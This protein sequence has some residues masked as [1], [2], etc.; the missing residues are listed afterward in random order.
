[1]G[2]GR[3]AAARSGPPAFAERR[4]CL[5]RWAGAVTR[6]QGAG[7]NPN[8][9]K[10][11]VGHLQVRSRLRLCSPKMATA[12]EHHEYYL[13]RSYL[14]ALDGLR[15]ISIVMVIWHHCWLTPPPG[16]WGK[17]PVGVQLFFVI[18]G[19]LVTTLLLRERERQGKVALAAFYRRRA[20]RIF[21]LYYA[22]LG[23][24]TIHAVIG[25]L[26]FEPSA[27]R[28][29]FFHNWPYFATFTCN[30][31]VD[32]TVPH[33]IT[34]AFAWTLAI[35]E[36]FYAFWAPVLRVLPG[37]LPPAA[38]ML[39]VMLLS[40]L[41]TWPWGAALLG[42]GLLRTVC[43]GLSSSIALGALLGLGLHHRWVGGTLLRVLSLPGMGIVS[44]L[45]A[46][47]CLE[48]FVPHLVFHA[49]LTG[50]VGA[51]V[52]TSDAPLVKALSRPWPTW[53]GRRSYG[54]YLTHFLAIGGV[55]AVIG[56]ERPI[57]TFCLALPL[58]LALAHVVFT[59]VERPF[60]ALKGG[61]ATLR[62]HPSQSR[63]AGE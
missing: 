60:L 1:M 18:S 9:R 62:G 32:W 45:A 44:A 43:D 39:A 59:W 17:G 5:T 20:L 37:L 3:R 21:P 16:I 15:A 24:L 36:Q 42:E 57:L 11:A 56:G 40:Q 50:L 8:G 22:V 29:H 35:E 55:R 51:C 53:I 2:H 48:F 38:F 31:W 61:H 30:W 14:P 6:R 13:S 28:A 49:A 34:F 12:R 25:E 4:Q 52:V 54:L 47:S 58:A 19:Y 41:S 27:Q 23:V 10:N 33:P 63:R 46:V 26:Y 7:P